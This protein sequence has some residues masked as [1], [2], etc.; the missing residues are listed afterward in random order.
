MP[1]SPPQLT[2]P[3]PA[4]AR[5]G[6]DQTADERVARA[7][8]QA[9]PPRQH[10]PQHR[11][12]R[13]RAD[14][15]NGARGGDGDDPGDRVGDGASQQQSP[16]DVEGGRHGD[17]RSWPRGT[18]GNQ[19][20]DRVRRVVKAVGDGE[21]ERDRDRQL[22]AHRSNHPTWAG[23]GRASVTVRDEDPVFA[24]DVTDGPEVIGSPIPEYPPRGA[25]MATV[26]KQARTS[27]PAARAAR[28]G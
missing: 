9:A 15:R 19:R 28:L 10:V 8:W 1:S 25:E 6:A 5:R 23:A 21:Q 24:P 26:E 7:R 4:S 17:R 2:A 27:G 22:E 14:H 3:T 12:E 20:G 13:A 11:G 18:G 16:Q